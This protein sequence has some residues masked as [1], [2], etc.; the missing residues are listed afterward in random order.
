[1]HI[2]VAQRAA[3]LEASAHEGIWV[4]NAGQLC[5]LNK[6]ARRGGRIKRA[7]AM[8]VIQFFS[9]GTGGGGGVIFES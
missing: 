3:E 8:R 1:M 4:N 6:H 7:T 2:A 5:L 9:W